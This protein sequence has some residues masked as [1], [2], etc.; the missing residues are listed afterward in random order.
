MTKVGVA[1]SKKRTSHDAGIEACSLALMFQFDCAGREIA[2]IAG[3]A[4]HHN[5]TVVL[6]AMYET[7]LD[8]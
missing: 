8:A 3:E 1:L 4:F 2:P 6:C 7:G 5:Y